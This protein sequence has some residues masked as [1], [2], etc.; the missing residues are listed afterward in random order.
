VFGREVRV[1]EL[2][3]HLL[4]MSRALEAFA[5]ARRPVAGTLKV[6]LAGVAGGGD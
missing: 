4:P 3:S 5:L 1:R 2:V 6:V